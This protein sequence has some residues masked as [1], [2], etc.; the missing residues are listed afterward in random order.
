MVLFHK[1]FLKQQSKFSLPIQNNIL[2]RIGLF[3]DNPFNPILNNHA[4]NH[5]YE[6][7][8]SINISGDVR[9]VYEIKNNGD[10]LFVRVGTH[11]ELYK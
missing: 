11:S 4:L 8:H 1:K 5:L 2:K 7:C 9:A 6:G 10:I 3:V